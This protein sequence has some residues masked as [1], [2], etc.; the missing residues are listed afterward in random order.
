MCV[1]V[2]TITGKDRVEREQGKGYTGEFVRKGRNV[3][4]ISKLRPTVQVVGVTQDAAASA[5]PV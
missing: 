3:I 5:A 4:I 2:T 1:C